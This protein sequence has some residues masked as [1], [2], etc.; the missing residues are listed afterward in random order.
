MFKYLLAL[1]FV[2]S[3]LVPFAFVS[4]ANPVENTLAIDQVSS[5]LVR[6]TIREAH[7]IYGV[8]EHTCSGFHLT[9]ERILTAAHCMGENILADGKSVTVLKVDTRYDLALLSTEHPKPGLILRDLPPRRFETLYAIGYAYGWTKLTVLQV[10]AFLI[11]HPVTDD[12]PV[13]IIVQGGYIGGMSGGPVID[14]FGLVVGIVQQ[15]NNAIGYGVGT[16]LI[17]AFLLGT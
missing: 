9:P 13:G 10:R 4:T 11:D 12:V 7:P 8:V 1:G 14:E 5:S 3:A 17:N 16:L 2:L 6:I 15:S